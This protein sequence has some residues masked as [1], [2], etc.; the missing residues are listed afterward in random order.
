MKMRAWL[1]LC[2]T[3]AQQARAHGH[4]APPHVVAP[5]KVMEVV[6]LTDD[7]VAELTRAPVEPSIDEDEL[8]AAEVDA[9]ASL[10]ADILTGQKFAFEV[11]REGRLTLSPSVL[12]AVEEVGE[13]YE[14]GHWTAW[15]GRHGADPSRAPT[16]VGIPGARLAPLCAQLPADAPAAHDPAGL[17]GA[18]IEKAAS[19]SGEAVI[20]P[21]AYVVFGGNASS[22]EFADDAVRGA[23]E[24][25]AGMLWRAGTPRSLS[26]ARGGARPETRFR[27]Y[28]ASFRL[29]ND[30]AAALEC[31]FTGGS[32]GHPLNIDYDGVYGQAEDAVI[33]VYGCVIPEG[34]GG[35]AFF[36]GSVHIHAAHLADGG[37][38]AHE[39]GHS[40]GLHHT[41]EGGC[42]S[43]EGDEVADTPQME[44]THSVCPELY[45]EKTAE[46]ARGGRARAPRPAARARAPPRPRTRSL[47]RPRALDPRRAQ[48][49][50]ATP[51]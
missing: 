1:L 3:F 20:V 44:A 38:L 2:A 19:A 12:E 18:P 43:E 28:V 22:R 15:C 17:V 9:L 42:A 23:N 21:L 35:Y 39:L 34:Y 46:C 8:T 50:R 25:F 45:A 49:R 4:A 24:L 36:G 48:T 32:S 10:A 14:R 30:D 37:M 5:V 26:R 6:A 33:N 27:F 11:L 7:E 51:G 16:E 29:V 47:A 41:F 31:H 40:L 13:M